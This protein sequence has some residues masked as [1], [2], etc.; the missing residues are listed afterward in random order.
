MWLKVAKTAKRLLS[1]MLCIGVVMNADETESASF[2]L[3]PPEF[4][5]SNSKDLA[6][7]EA[8]FKGNDTKAHELVAK[9]ADP[10]AE[11][12]TSNPYNRLRL[13]HYAIAKNSSKAVTVLVAA[14]ADPEMDTI[15]GAGSP[16]HFTLS[17]DRIEMLSLLLDLRPIELLSDDTLR[18]LLFESVVLSRPR[19]LELLLKKGVPIDFPDKS[20][21]TSMM[22][23]MDA[24]DF[25]LAEW[26]ILN[27]A[28]VHTE[29]NGGMT[30]AYS[31]QYDLQKF[32]PG[33]PTHDKVL[34]LK[35]IMEEK[36][37]VFP[38]PSPA[39]VRDKRVPK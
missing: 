21:H 29:A 9:G 10:N 24:Q 3:H 6:L 14:G 1:L 27:G 17:L 33:T 19:C 35:K 20:G 39:E 31:I 7:L 30:P 28:S 5:F 36:G 25:D 37:V 13:L 11:G 18:H 34:R 22:R 23:A 8:A 2:K 15:G 26:L 16:F 4:Y 38:A 12:P 32:R